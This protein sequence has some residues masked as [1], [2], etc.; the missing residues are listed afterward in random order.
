[1][2]NFTTQNKYVS[3]LHRIFR[4]QLRSVSFL[5]LGVLL[6]ACLVT[7]TMLSSAHAAVVYYSDRT[8]WTTAI[9]GA[10]DWTV[11]FDSFAVDTEFRTAA[12]DLGP[13][14]LL[15]DTANTNVDLVDVPPYEGSISA[16]S[17]TTPAANLYVSTGNPNI[18]AAP[19]T[20]TMTFDSPTTAWGADFYAVGV[21]VAMLIEFSDATTET[22]DVS[23]GASELFLGL[24]S[25]L[26]ISKITFF[27]SA[28]GTLNGDAFLIDDV[29][30]VSADTSVVPL[31]AALPL[32]AGGLGAMGLLGWRRKRKVSAR[33]A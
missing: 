19:E 4:T 30:G 3:Y 23:A 31:P 22:K 16:N 21:F 15:G 13:F 28:T 9:G 7:F 17:D 8:S 29:Q 6:G 20:A 24:T 14:S 25:T 11:D 26:G 2:R 33:A 32:F 1:M 10:A 18:G 5:R 12:L 27:N